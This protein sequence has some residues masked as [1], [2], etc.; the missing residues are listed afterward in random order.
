MARWIA[1]LG[2]AVVVG[3]GRGPLWPID[4]DS[5]GDD[6]EAGPVDC[7]RADFV[8]VIDDSPSMQEYQRQLVD[9][10][11]VFID[12]V[13]R[14]VEHNTDL[15]VGVI[16]TDAYVG[17]PA[18]CNVLGGF[19]VATAGA[20]SSRATCGPYAEGNT[21]M[22]AADDLA[23]SFACAASVGTQ[24]AQIEQPAAAL[25]AAL[26]PDSDA[27]ECNQGFLRDDALLVAVLLTDE[28]DQSPGYPERWAANVVDAK[29]G[30]ADAVVAVALLRKDEECADGLSNDCYPWALQQFTEEFDHGFLGPITG[31]YGTLFDAAVDVVATACAGD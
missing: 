4:G 17:N 22:T 26:D 2:L 14:V 31:D 9:N 13:Q 16:T 7:D 1:G 20:H 8:F 11:P 29:H 6:G 19:V 5:A 23:A 28:P 3:C 25:Q 30:N 12:G 27:A 18:P 10:F 21:W 15:H 24:G